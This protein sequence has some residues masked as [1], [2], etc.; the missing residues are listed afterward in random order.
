MGE[1]IQRTNINTRYTT[2]IT[3]IELVNALFMAYWLTLH[4]PTVLTHRIRVRDV[5]LRDEVPSELM[6]FLGSHPAKYQPPS[7]VCAVQCSAEVCT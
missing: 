5:G 7:V 4:I 3:D 2:G 1:L 6:V